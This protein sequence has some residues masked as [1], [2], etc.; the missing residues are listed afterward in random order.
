MRSAK[1]ED[2]EQAGDVGRGKRVGALDR[3]CGHIGDITGGELAAVAAEGPGEERIDPALTE[4]ID[5][6]LDEPAG[7]IEV[8]EVVAENGLGVLRIGRLELE[9][10]KAGADAAPKPA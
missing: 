3:V 2:G 9:H 10:A 7:E 4:L 6:P 1:C 8:Q 5:V